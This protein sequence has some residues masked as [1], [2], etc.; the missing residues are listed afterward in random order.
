[1]AIWRSMLSGLLVWTGHFFGVYAASS[2]FPGSLV[3]RLLTL[4]ITLAALAAAAWLT[5]RALGRLRAENADEVNRWLDGIALAGGAL[6]GTAILY[7][8][9][10]ALLA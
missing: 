7:Q 2:L 9:L 6:A 8:G 3:A 4:A 1:M 5:W 10:P